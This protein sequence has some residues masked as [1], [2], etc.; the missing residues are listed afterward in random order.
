LIPVLAIAVVPPGRFNHA[1]PFVNQLRAFAFAFATPLPLLRLCLC[2]H[3]RLFLLSLPY[4]VSQ[5]AG[6][7]DAGGAAIAVNFWYD[8]RFDSPNYVAFTHQEFCRQ[9][10]LA[11]NAASTD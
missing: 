5:S 11:M 3:S 8:M 7:D 2:Y 6:D 9:Q 4:Q 10:E 1:C